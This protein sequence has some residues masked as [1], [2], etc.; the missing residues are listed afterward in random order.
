ME[1]TMQNVLSLSNSL[2]SVFWAKRKASSI[3]NAALIL[4]GVIAIAISAHIEIPLQPVPITLQDFA[5]LFIGMTYGWRLA[6]L[7][8]MS[9]LFLG[10]IGLPVFASAGAFAPS[11]GF[12]F[13]FLPAAALSGYLVEK[14]WGRHIITTALAGLAGLVVVF[15]GGLAVLSIFVGWE[16]SIELGLM[17]FIFGDSLKLIFLSIV[18]PTFWKKNSA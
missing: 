11:T 3:S 2:T 9:Y 13:S 14:G 12:L 16:K 7:T 1:P 4:L 8:V 6:S 18:I 15:A 10:M 5:V 17:P